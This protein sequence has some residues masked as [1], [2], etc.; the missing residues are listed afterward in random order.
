M[1][2]S[3]RADFSR[4]GVIG[5]SGGDNK[6]TRLGI[7]PQ[8]VNP[9]DMNRPGFRRHLAQYVMRRLE[10]AGALETRICPMFSVDRGLE[11]WDYAMGRCMGCLRSFGGL[12]WNYR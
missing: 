4:S 11:N 3:G 6:I 5:E 12:R 1:P 10:A 7:V 9:W 8:D 2:G